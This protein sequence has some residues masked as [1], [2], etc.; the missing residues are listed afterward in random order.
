M[1]GIALEYFR[2]IPYIYF[3]TWYMPGIYHVYSWHIPRICSWHIPGICQVYTL[4]IQKKSVCDVPL[5][6]VTSVLSDMPA[7]GARE[8]ARALK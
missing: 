6:A 2:Y 5:S 8:P 3:F 4:N 1:T 7:G